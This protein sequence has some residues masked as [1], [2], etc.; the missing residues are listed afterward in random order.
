M[1]GI[2]RD[3]WH[4]NDHGWGWFGS[5]GPTDGW[6]NGSG[7]DREAGSWKGRGGESPG[8]DCG[9]GGDSAE[10]G[11]I[12]VGDDTANVLT[13]GG[14]DDFIVANGGDDVVFAGN[15]DDFVLA[16][17]GDD[18]IHGGCGNDTLLGGEDDDRIWGDAGDDLTDGD[19]GNDVLTG[20]E[21]ADTFQFNVGPE[22]LGLGSDIVT[23]FTLGE[24]HLEIKNGDA[25]L[26][27][28]ADTGTD[29]A[30]YYDGVLIA[31]LQGVADIPQD[32]SLF[33][34]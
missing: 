9:C 33:F 6:R 8:G 30:V 4:S 15:G 21:G 32:T 2:V 11:Q 20:G 28:F 24:D 22:Y 34:A 23:D 19:R 7:V 31:E 13:G 29:V 16:N 26:V 27:T 10:A 25:S 1:G 17:G 18:Q 5:G 12:I 3:F 14:G